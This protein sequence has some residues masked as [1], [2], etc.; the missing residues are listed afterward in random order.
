LSPSAFI[1]TASRSGVLWTA[2]V[3]R[4]GDGAFARRDTLENSNV[5]PKW[6]R[7]SLAPAVQ[8]QLLPPPMPRD[9]G[10]L[11]PRLLFNPSGTRFSPLFK[12]AKCDLD[13]GSHP[14]T[15]CDWFTESPTTGFGAES[16][17]T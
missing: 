7:A 8:N 2:P 5:P 17:K 4:S 10:I 14:V 11:S 16:L 12:V 6:G 15:N 1:I 3:E 13:S 9:S